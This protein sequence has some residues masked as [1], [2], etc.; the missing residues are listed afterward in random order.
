MRVPADI[1]APSSGSYPE[2]LPDLEYDRSLRVCRVRPNGEIRWRGARLYAGE[3]FAGENVALDY[4]EDGLPAPSVVPQLIAILSE[5]SK[6][7]LAPKDAKP[8]L[9]SLRREAEND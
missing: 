7:F 2:T 4:F 6:D 9:R 3:V 1:Y 5:F 8:H